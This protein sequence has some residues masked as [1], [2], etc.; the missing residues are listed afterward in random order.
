M[1][2]ANIMNFRFI[3]T[4]F[5]D[6]KGNEVLIRTSDILN[7]IAES[8]GGLC[9]RLGGDQFAMLMTRQGFSEE[10]LLEAAQILAKDFSSGMYTFCIHFGVYEVDDPSIPVSVMCGRANSALRTIRE[11]LT[12]TVA[13]F[14]HDILERMLLE[15]KVIGG[16]EDALNGGEFR[17]YLQPMV[18]ENSRIIG[19]EALARWVRPDGSMIMPDQFIETL[20][21]AG[22]IQKLDMYI[23]E[24]AA[25]QLS[26][27]KGTDKQELTISVNMSARDFYSIDVYDVLTELVERYGIDSSKLR[28]EIT[29]TALLVEPEK[30]NAIVTD[31]RRKGFI[32]EIDD[33]GKGY[34]SLSLMK[35]IHADVIKIDKDFLKEIR[36]KDRNRMILNSV[37][38][39]AGSLGMDI[40][41]EGVETERQHKVLTEMGCRHFQGFY[42]S[43]PVPVDEF[44]D[45]CRNGYCRQEEL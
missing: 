14:N 33:F 18:D 2:T 36:D 30:S 40:I 8:A 11:D 31:L 25:R 22:L 13:H 24:L 29:E 42:F 20:E 45:K 9:G 28:L 16:F 35:S 44:E 7:E 34:S 27:W 41:V 15:H 1:V 43:R 39:L 17:M 26:A 10:S 3:N 19:A 6:L 4:L 21:N 37:I 38:S 12:Q 23:W 5:G 32:V